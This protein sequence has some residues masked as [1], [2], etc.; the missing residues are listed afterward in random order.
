MA[1]LKKA[2]GYIFGLGVIEGL[3]SFISILALILRPPHICVPSH[4]SASPLQESQIFA[5]AFGNVGLD[6]KVSRVVVIG[7]CDGE[8]II[9]PRQS[10]TQSRWIQ[11]AFDIRNHLCEL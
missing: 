11:D 2:D 7:C 10:Q 8:P 6:R 3:F 5:F 9:P 4:A 1:T